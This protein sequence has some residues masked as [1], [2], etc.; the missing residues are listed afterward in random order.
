MAND[1]F[2]SERQVAAI[3]PFSTRTLQRWRV[4]GDGPRWCRL[5]AKRVAYRASDLETWAS[6][7]TFIHRAEELSRKEGAS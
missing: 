1:D 5:G 7:N 3:Y 2:L 4:T 6:R